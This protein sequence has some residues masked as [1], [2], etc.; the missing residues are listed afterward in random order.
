MF[1]TKENALQ[2]LAQTAR[3]PEYTPEMIRGLMAALDL[4][5]KG[6]A[7]LMNV[8]PTAVRCW[9]SGAVRPGGTAK[10]LMQ[11]YEIGPELI[12]KLAC[13]QSL[14]DGKNV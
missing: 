6:F 5:E 12:G 10:R 1:E 9:T 13:E 3:C 14:Q 4:N 7:L 11:F 2:M 8:T